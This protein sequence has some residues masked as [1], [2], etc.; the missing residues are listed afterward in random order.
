[1]V[2]AAAAAAPPSSWLARAAQGLAKVGSKFSPAY[3]IAAKAAAPMMQGVAAGGGYVGANFVAQPAKGILGFFVNFFPEAGT[4]VY[5]WFVWGA[6]FLYL[7]DWASGFNAAA[8]ASLHLWFAAAAFLIFGVT[9]RF[10][11]IPVAASGIVLFMSL[12]SFMQAERTF[13]LNSFSITSLALAFFIYWRANTPGF[14]KYLPLF[15]FVDVYALPVFRD[16]LLELTQNVNYLSLALAFVTNRILFPIWL[17]FGIFAFSS[18]APPSTRVARKLLAVMIAF[19]LIVS[20]PQ[21]AEAYSTKVSSLTP[22][23][24]EVAQ[25]VWARFQ[26]NVGA[27]IRGIV[28]GEFLKAPVASVYEKAEIAFGF[29]KAKEEPKMGLQLVNNPNMQQKFDLAY[30]DVPAASVTLTVPNPLPLDLKQ[31]YIGVT[32]IKCEDTSESGTET[33][34]GKID[35]PGREPSSGK[36]FELYYGDDQTGVCIFPGI[37]KHSVK[38]KVEYR[39]EETAYFETTI[40]RDDKRRALLAKQDDPA[41]KREL[42]NI[43]PAKAEYNNGP[44]AI[45]WD[46]PALTKAPVSN[47]YARKIVVVVSNSGA[48]PGELAGIEWLEVIAP[49]GVRLEGEPCSFTKKQGYDNVYEV[50]SW[51]IRTKDGKGDLRFIGDKITFE[52]G[53]VFDNSFLGGGDTAGARFDARGSFIFSTSPSSAVT[54]E[55]INSGTETTSPKTAA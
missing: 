14:F 24:K 3:G 51:K 11:S 31:R 6:A 10:L 40:M 2:E 27:S 47:E 26:T 48:W 18:E 49:Q 43:P 12:Y 45:K 55:V 17:W 16:R 9:G 53:L 37:A 33:K 30:K 4:N 54:F 42:S 50:A 23:E 39:V 52:C 36:P 1:M 46:P 44:A 5:G 41:V 32:G 34:T 28:S 19:Y 13:A 8:T 20:A 29:G 15:A 25:T 21:I 7:M 38:F 35:P 22:E